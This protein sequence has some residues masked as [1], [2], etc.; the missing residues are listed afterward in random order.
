M[1]VPIWKADAAR[2]DFHEAFSR[3]SVARI[4]GG[5]HSGAERTFCR[6]L[7]VQSTNPVIFE[8]V[9]LPR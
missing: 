4:S 7:L 2:L 8:R 6:E 9:E 3:N 5:E 1:R